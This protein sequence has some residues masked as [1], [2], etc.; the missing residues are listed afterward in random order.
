[1][2]RFLAMVISF[3]IFSLISFFA[4][5][6]MENGRADPYYRK[7]TTSTKHSLILGNSKGGQGLIPTEI[8]RILAN[9]FQ[10]ELYNFCFTLYASPYGPSYLDAIKKK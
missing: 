6:L 4:I 10:G 5:F 7:F 3:S 9:Q 8:D 2:K 1:M